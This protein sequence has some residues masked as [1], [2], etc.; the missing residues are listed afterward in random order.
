MGDVAELTLFADYHQIHVFDEDS[1]TDLGDL[2][3]DRAMVDRLALGPDALAVG[4]AVNVD[5]AVAVEVLTGSPADDS[6]LFDHVVEAGI[7]CRSGRL[8]IMGCTDYAPD[9]HRFDVTAGSLRIR[10]SQSN[11]DAAYRAGIDADDDPETMERL[12]LQVWPA[13][14]APAVVMKRWQP[15]EG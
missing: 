7:E 1:E 10:A 13:A 14:P 8:V 11:L 6:D 5:I 9:A 15:A 2:W 3:T 12:R 4:T